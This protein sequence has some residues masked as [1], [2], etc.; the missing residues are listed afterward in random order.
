MGE[1]AGYSDNPIVYEAQRDFIASIVANGWLDIPYQWGGTDFQNG[2]DCSQFTLLSYSS[3][4]GINTQSGF[5]DGSSAQM[6]YANGLGIVDAIEDHSITSI[7]WSRMQVGDLIFLNLDVEDN[8]QYSENVRHVMVFAGYGP[9]PEYFPHVVHASGEADRT[10]LEPF[11]LRYEGQISHV[12]YGFLDTQVNTII[13]NQSIL[14]NARYRVDADNVTLE[15]IPVV[16]PPPYEARFSATGISLMDT[17]L[18]QNDI[19]LNNMGFNIPDE[20]ARSR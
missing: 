9:P 12:A 16:V 19:T 13:T 11:P 5:P 6:L 8:G 10:I 7:D 1:P 20:S 3:I 17:D 14:L 15:N 4:F 18:N 2:L